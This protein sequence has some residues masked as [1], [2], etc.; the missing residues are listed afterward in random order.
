MAMARDCGVAQLHVHAFLDGRDTPPQSAGASLQLIGMKAAEL[1]LGRIAS[2]IGRY[3]AMD[4]NKNWER[5]RQ[6]YELLVDGHPLHEAADPLIALDQAYARGETDEFVKATAIV[7]AG[8][9]PTR[10]AD[11]DV[12]GFANFRADRA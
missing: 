1:G 6:A 11:G 8:G 12:V 2:I 5:T 3:Y 10:I 4:R 9:S 7:P